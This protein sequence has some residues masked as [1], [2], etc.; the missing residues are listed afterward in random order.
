MDKLKLCPFCGGEAVLHVD[1][2]VRVICKKCRC[3]T[4]GLRDS[5]AL[6][7]Y[8]GNAVKTVIEKWN[9]RTD[10]LTEK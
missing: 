5:F 10:D 8:T 6:G 4:E 9:R 2:G 3:R 1:D 7:S